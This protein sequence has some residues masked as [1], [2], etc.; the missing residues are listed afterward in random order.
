MALSGALHG[1]NNQ[2]I[3]QKGRKGH[4]STFQGPMSSSKSMKVKGKRGSRFSGKQGQRRTH[5]TNGESSAMNGVTNSSGCESDVCD[6]LSRI[7][8]TL[9][10][11]NRGRDSRRRDP[12]VNGADIYVARITKNGTGGAK[13]CWRCLE[14]CRWAGVKRV[15]H[16]DSELGKFDAVKVNST[17]RDQYETHADGRLYAGLGW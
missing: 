15:F 17:E 4:T 3:E 12:R 14:W 1:V 7:T 6:R 2:N 13:P 5:P 11:V 10:D 9:R 8:H 16:W